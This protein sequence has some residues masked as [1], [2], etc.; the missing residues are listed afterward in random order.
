MSYITKDKLSIILGKIR[1]NFLSKTDMDKYI[2]WKEYSD[3]DSI[4]NGDI[5]ITS[6]HQLRSNGIY[7]IPQTN[8]SQLIKIL[9]PSQ[10]DSSYRTCY[11][12]NNATNPV[13]EFPSDYKLN[14]PENCFT[15]IENNG[16]KKLISAG[17]L[18]FYIIYIHLT[19]KGIFVD[20]EAT[21]DSSSYYVEVSTFHDLSNYR[22]LNYDWYRLNNRFVNKITI[23]DKPVALNEINENSFECEEVNKLVKIY[24][25]DGITSLHKMFY[26]CG[27][28]SP[29]LNNIP[30]TVYDFSYMFAES[31]IEYFKQDSYFSMPD[32]ANC[33]GMFKNCK[34]LKE[35]SQY[36]NIM[37]LNWKG[38]A[39]WNSMFEGCEN[40]EYVDLD[41]W[42]LKDGCKITADRMF[43]GCFD[44]TSICLPKISTISKPYI[45]SADH[46][47]AGCSYLNLI[48]SKFWQLYKYVYKDPTGKEFVYYN[49]YT[50]GDNVNLNIKESP[51][52]RWSDIP[53]NKQDEYKKL[54]GSH[55]IQNIWDKLTKIAIEDS[56]LPGI[57]VYR[58]TVVFDTHVFENQDL[59]GYNLAIVPT[60]ALYNNDLQYIPIAGSS[61]YG[62]INDTSYMCGSWKSID[63]SPSI[64]YEYSNN[65]TQYKYAYGIKF[66]DFDNG[67]YKN[68]FLIDLPE[69]TNNPE[70]KDKLLDKLIT[71]EIYKSSGQLNTTHDKIL[72]TDNM[73]YFERINRCIYVT[74]KSA[75]NDIEYF[76][77][78]INSKFYDN[79]SWTNSFFGWYQL[80]S[81][82]AILVKTSNSHV[83]AYNSDLQERL[84]WSRTY[85]M[86]FIKENLS[87]LIINKLNV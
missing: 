8:N 81:I 84:K 48:Y 33:E 1:E 32:C 6:D 11:Y 68:L 76:C 29:Y 80:G 21:V 51:Y 4:Q 14:F 41:D 61:F 25:K 2:G 75:Y 23:G 13:F 37:K 7:K 10:I 65:P 39:N 66:W 43:Y 28:N 82:Y 35:D 57:G 44:L 87:D 22:Y 26:K 27:V 47:F 69:L 70:F 19:T 45:V 42:I 5:N 60:Y 18:N 9:K 58:S 52:T 30:S 86:K 53:K 15:L 12:C 67:S 74:S 56:N 77:Y 24:L 59:L 63:E 79:T 73:N 46:M 85:A 78:D 16:I 54:M 3:F 49:E 64:I 34:Q 83:N 55:G 50:G 71:E 40:L 72:N 62:S 20:I 36:A 31:D 38:D 17:S